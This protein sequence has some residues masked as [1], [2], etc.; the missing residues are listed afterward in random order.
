MHVFALPSVRFWN[1]ND[2]VKR[3]VEG[4]DFI[5]SKTPI[6]GSTAN[7]WDPVINQSQP[8]SMQ[9]ANEYTYT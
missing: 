7:C 9:K 6:L 3:R 1:T 2:K 8:H 4:K 5:K